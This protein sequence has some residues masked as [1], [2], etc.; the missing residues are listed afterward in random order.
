VDDRVAEAFLEALS[1][2]EIDLYEKAMAAREEMAD[3]AEHAGR[4]QLQRLHYQAELARRRFER[5]DPDNRLVAAELERRWEG[6][7]RELRQAEE[8]RPV[9]LHKDGSAPAE[10][11][12][13][14]K[15]TFKSIGR[16][17]PEIWDGELPSHKQRK[18]LLRCLVEG[19]ILRRVAPD[20]IQT[21]IVW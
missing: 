8:T 6:A 18:A 10:L 14:L 2:V 4:Q 15:R 20:T 12:A 9:E 19:V 13:D 5:A 1:P 16:R 17:L 21:R 11:T 3:A 7:L